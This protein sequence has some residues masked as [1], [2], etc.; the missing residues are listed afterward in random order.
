MDASFNGDRHH[1]MGDKVA[2]AISMKYRR[3]A[4]LRRRVSM[5]DDVLVL[6]QAVMMEC[7]VVG[8]DARI[9]VRVCA[10]ITV[11]LLL[12][13]DAVTVVTADMA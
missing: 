1:C 4:Q 10:T 5:R 6:L 9:A 3:L 13:V 7:G 8:G 11:C 12:E 2:T